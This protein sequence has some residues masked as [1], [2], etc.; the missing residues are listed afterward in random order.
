MRGAGKAS[1]PEILFHNPNSVEDTVN[2]LVKA[3]ARHV[4][5]LEQ[6]AAEHGGARQAAVQS[7]GQTES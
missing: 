2:Y 7:A 6:A 3:L 1:A 4:A 5:R